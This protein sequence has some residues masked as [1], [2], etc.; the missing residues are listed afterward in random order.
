VIGMGINVRHAPE[1]IPYPV[2]S[3]FNIGSAVSADTLFSALSDAW[4]EQETL[5]NEGRGFTS[6]RDNWLRRAAGLG[7]PIAVRTDGDLLRGTFETIDDEGRLIVRDRSGSV[8][9]ISAGD[10]HFGV[11]A[12]AAF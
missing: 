9:A 10:V 11:A 3:L 1:G 12:T 4:V 7:A 5:W 8:T 2:T 6:I